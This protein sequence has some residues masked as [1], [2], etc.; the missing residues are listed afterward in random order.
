M[1]RFIVFLITS[2][3]IVGN[4]NAKDCSTVEEMDS[5]DTVISSIKNWQDVHSFFA[6]LKQCDDGGMAEGISDAVVKL[7][8]NKWDSVEELAI[9]TR[10]DKNFQEWVLIHINATVNGDDLESIIS[11]ARDECPADNRKLCENIGTSAK[12][13]LQA[14]TE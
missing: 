10:Q 4:V 6:T 12:Q 14:L 8:A 3:L 13:A 5:A 11:H 1:I 9:L 2:F 7:L